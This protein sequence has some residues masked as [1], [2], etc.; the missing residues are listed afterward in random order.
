MK[1]EITETEARHLRRLIAKELTTYKSQQS[2]VSEIRLREL[3]K[4]LE[5]K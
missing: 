3:D 4:K 1:I 2:V 5:S